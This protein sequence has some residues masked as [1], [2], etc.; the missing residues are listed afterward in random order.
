[1]SS[2]CLCTEAF[3][4]T[5]NNSL[6]KINL[7]VNIVWKVNL[8][9]TSAEGKRGKEKTKPS[10]FSLSISL[11]FFLLVKKFQIFGL[12]PDEN[13]WIRACGFIAVTAVS[14]GLF[15]GF[16]GSCR[17]YARGRSNLAN[18]FMFH[19]RKFYLLDAISVYFYW[20]HFSGLRDTRSDLEVTG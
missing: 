14:L 2:V 7:N 12:P 4:S 19:K 13:S 1:M 6:P 11:F 15:A 9:H 8:Y 5:K 10:V 18:T 16:S 3:N 17:K 20:M